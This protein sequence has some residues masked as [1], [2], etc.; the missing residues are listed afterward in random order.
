MDIIKTDI[1]VVGTGLAGAIAAITAADKGAKVTVLTKT[2]VLMGGNTPYAQGGIVYEGHEDSPEKLKN[3]I[4]KA[5]DKHCWE[6]AV[7]QLCELGP[8]LVK[9]LLI[10]KYLVDFDKSKSNELDLTAEGA[11]SEPRIIHSKDNTGETIQ[12]SILEELKNHPNIKIL[13]DHT[14]VDLLTLSHHSENSLDIYKKPACFGAFVLN[15]STG[16]VFAIYSS[17]TILA[18]GGLGRIFRHSSNPEESTGDGIALA[19]RAG[20]RCFNLEY[21]QFHPTTFYNEHDRFLISESMRGEG[22]LLVD[23]FGHSFMERFHELG[24][25]APRDIVARGIH[26]V[27]L[28]TS[29]PCVYLDI[30]HKSEQWIKDRFPTIYNHCYDAGVDITSEPVPV[31]PAAHY[32]CGGVGV[33][34]RGRTSLKRLYAV[35]EV[36]CTGVHGANRLASTSLLEAVIWGYIAGND[37]AEHVEG[38][39]YFPEIYAWEDEKKLVD[40]ALVA[41][42][43]MTIKNTMWNYVGLIR[44]KQR[45]FRAHT[46][47]RHLQSEI[48]QFYRKVKMTKDVLQLRNGVQTAIAVTAATMESHESRGTHYLHEE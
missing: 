17:N 8:K 32:S 42:D 18:T 22:A 47:L 38:E 1:L 12:K 3:D 13:T 27:M 23:K 6:T 5:G 35:G 21:I 7:N 33:S 10:D 16:K 19:W 44:T 15:N 26:Q 37:A 29:H 25:L 36:S 9:D 31:V 46:I 11:H 30:S 14:V 45:L 41:Q 48:D 4:L 34:L 39:N 20:A 24:S 40:P 2:P 28:E 43:W